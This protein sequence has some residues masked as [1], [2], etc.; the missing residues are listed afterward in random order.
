MGLLYLKIMAIPIR[1]IVPGVVGARNVK[2]LGKI[3]LSEEES[4]SHWQQNDYKGFA[5]N[6]DWDTVDFKKSPAI[7]D[8]PVT[9]AIC[10]PLEGETVKIKKDG[11]FEVKG[12]SY[13]GGG[14]KTIRV[15]ISTDGGKTWREVD[16]LISDDAKHPRA[17]GWSIWKARVKVPDGVNKMELV[18][19]AVDSSYN[20][21]PENF[22]SIWNLRGLLSNAYHRVNIEVKRK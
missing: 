7:Q 11:A 5:P 14:R 10:S 21:Q 17:W 2:W 6:I 15:D 19:K 13:S 8:M 18:V 20:T 22:S 4:Q 3:I 1:V 12:Y 16:E 9:S